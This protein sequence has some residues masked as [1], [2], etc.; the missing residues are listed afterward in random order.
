MP[1]SATGTGVEAQGGPQCC[2]AAAIPLDTEGEGSSL[3]VMGSPIAAL[4]PT[5]QDPP[6]HANT[7]GLL[8]GE[9][10]RVGCLP[11]TATPSPVR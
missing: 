5:L 3:F 10:P 4:G 11:I 9:G 2:E 8:A 7:Q 6:L 1:F